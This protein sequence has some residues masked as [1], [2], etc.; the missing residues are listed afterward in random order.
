VRPS[1]TLPNR[2]GRR[3]GWRRPLLAAG[4]LVALGCAPTGPGGEP[5]DPSAGKADGDA[6]RSAPPGHLGPYRITARGPDGLPQLVEGTLGAGP[7]EGLAS[8]RHLLGIDDDRSVFDLTR[9]EDIDG[10]THLYY[11]Q[12][13]EDRSLPN[14]TAPVVGGDVTVHLDDGGVYAVS[15]TARSLEGTPTAPTITLANAMAAG[16]T[17]VQET[18]GYEGA[19][20]EAP[21]TV[22]S[23]YVITDAGT[24][25]LA[26]PVLARRDATGGRLP[27]DD[28]LYVDAERGDVV[29]TRP[30]I[31]PLFEREIYHA[32]EATDPADLPGELQRREDDEAT[33]NAA[34]DR[35]YDNLGWAETTMREIAGAD[36]LARVFDAPSVRLRATVGFGEELPGAFW[37][38][39]QKQ[40][41]F[42]TGNRRIDAMPGSLDVV[43][44]ELGHGFTRKTADLVYR[45][46][47][48]ALNEAWSDIWGATC[49]LLHARSTMD[50]D[51]R[52]ER[53]TAIS[54]AAW[55]DAFLVGEDAVRPAYPHRALRF[56]AEP[57]RDGQ[58]RDHLSKLY[59]GLADNG[60]VHRNSGIVN[61]AFYLMVRGG[62]HPRV[63]E[64][65]AIDDVYVPPMEGVWLLD[66]EG[67]HPWR[68]V[69]GWELAALVF[70]RAL[71]HYLTPNATFAMARAATLRAVTDLG[72]AKEYD[73]VDAAWRAVGVVG[74]RQTLEPGQT[75]EDLEGNP[76]T[77]RVFEVDVPA[78]AREA[79]IELQG[80][81]GYADLWVTREPVSP[82]DPESARERA[83]VSETPG[84]NDERIVLEEPG[85][86]YVL[87]RGRP[88]GYA[89][90]TLSMTV[91]AFCA[92][93]NASHVLREGAR[94]LLC[95]ESADDDYAVEV[96]I[97]EGR[98][99]DVVLTPDGTADLF[100][101]LDLLARHDAP[102]GPEA[103]DRSERGPGMPEPLTLGPEE[104]TWH[105]R[106]DTVTPP[107]GATRYWLAL[108]EANGR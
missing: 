77:P 76:R 40:V 81:T 45:R 74:E 41:V 54:E 5:G 46:E 3:Y 55:R 90:A 91:D 53:A 39:E 67:E 9:R 10:E 82:L 19:R 63:G 37:L 66:T 95:P 21:R 44:H 103:F 107:A 25:H 56:M 23:T 73:T 102:A 65:D 38:H 75:I 87:V 14:G 61:L 72:F 34:V 59:R 92:A 93:P 50:D 80:G 31:N 58:S 24:A 98:E 57:T 8:A 97:D 62:Q 60:G 47:S 83:M 15:G 42:G 94:L 105:V 27:L 2:A 43:C 64:D 101:D 79:R 30:R 51:A 36:A 104:G 1:S 99:L 71:T 6:D 85:R 17:F 70:Y 13:A 28:V 48:G 49:E 33:G 108:Q 20:V 78:D 32:Q 35:L 26:L 88:G 18:E 12:R 100:A 22:A 4:L 52:A 69:E 84:S 29:D 89:G 96:R 16:R 106:V 7:D 86:H 68:F 11:R